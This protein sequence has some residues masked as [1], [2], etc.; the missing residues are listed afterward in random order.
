MA[1]SGASRPNSSAA[2]FSLFPNAGEDFFNPGFFQGISGIG[3]ELLRLAWP[4]KIPSVLVF[5]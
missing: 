4:E 2:P 5:E 1:L 3:Y